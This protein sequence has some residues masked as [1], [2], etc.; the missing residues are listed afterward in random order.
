MR[1]GCPS[2]YSAADTLS[3]YKQQLSPLGSLTPSLVDDCGFGRIFRRNLTALEDLVAASS[4]FHSS[5]TIKQGL[6]FQSTPSTKSLNSTVVPLSVSL[7]LSCALP[8]SPPSLP[9]ELHGDTY[10]ADLKHHRMPFNDFIIQANSHLCCPCGQGPDR[11]A[12]CDTSS[13]VPL[14]RCLGIPCPWLPEWAWQN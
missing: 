14:D 3:L 2:S 10:E 6:V 8:T 11:L 5:T 1:L 9:E 13:S 12:R 4:R 7:D